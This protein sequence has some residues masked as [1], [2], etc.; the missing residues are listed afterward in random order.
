MHPFKKLAFCVFVL[1]AACSPPKPSNI[2]A[3][4]DENDSA[5]VKAW[6][7]E[8]GN[9]NIRLAS[10]EGLPYVATG[11]HGG[12]AVLIA[13]LEAGADPNLA[14]HEYTPLMNAASWTDAEAVQILLAHG[15]NPNLS[16]KDG[17]VALDFVLPNNGH[18]RPVIE[19]LQRAALRPRP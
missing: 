10:G 2:F 5:F 11:P 17:K 7:K 19:A 18:D 16:N 12:H 8:G 15:A 13:R 9:P 6:I 1:L 3:A 4:V 14:Y